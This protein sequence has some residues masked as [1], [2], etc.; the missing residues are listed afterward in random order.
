M[1]ILVIHGVILLFS[2]ISMF[3]EANRVKI[4]NFKI[5]ETLSSQLWHTSFVFL[6]VLSALTIPPKPPSPHRPL[7]C[8]WPG[9]VSLLILFLALKA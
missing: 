1:R 9:K 3:D 4:I 7:I 6:F 2:I 5:K 8:F